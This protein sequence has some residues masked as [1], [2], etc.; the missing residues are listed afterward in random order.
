MK[1]I[2]KIA[3]IGGGFGGWYTATALQYNCPHVELVIID[4]QEH[5][6]I[7]VGEVTGFDAPIHY[8][9][10]I[11]VSDPAELFKQTGAIYKFGT[12]A[13]NFYQDNHSVSWGKFPNLKIKS[14]K[15]FFQ[16]W[17]EHDFYE[18]WNRQPGDV[19]VLLAWMILN[20][21]TGKTYDD[22]QREVADQNYFVNNPCAPVLD[23]QLFLPQKNSYGYQV[24]ADQTIQFLKNLVYTRDYSRFNHFKSPVVTVKR[25]G[26]EVTGVVLEDGTEV[27]ADLFIDASGMHR[28]LMKTGVNS[29]WTPAGDDYNNAAWVFPSAYKN[30]HMELTGSTDFYGEDH[31]WRF[32]VRLYHRMGN[33]YIFNKNFVDPEVVKEDFLRVAGETKLKDPKLIQWTPGHYAEPWQGNVIPVG[34]AGWFIDPWNAPTFDLHSKSLEDLINMIKNWDLIEDHRAHFNKSRAL[35]AEERKLRLDINFGL[36]KRSGPF[37][38]RCREMAKNNG[39]LEKLRDLVLEKRTDLEERLNWYW[40]H[41]YIL[42]AIATGVDTTTWEFPELTYEDKNMVDAYFNYTK[43]RNHYIS[44]YTWPN[45][46]EWLRNKVFNNKESHEMLAILNPDLTK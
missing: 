41:M 22:Y 10:L 37:W 30:P 29:S 11:G 9:R 3:I 24:D 35:N 8:S 16:P 13:I 40:I 1:P 25:E 15:N 18:P 32:K 12:N 27:N 31:G 45:Y 4:S 5:A 21:N 28:V 26:S 38:D 36:S 17:D 19:G 23:R 42:V 44:R 6:P 46:Y 39:T 2:Q 33:G 34:I 20:R 7:G 43:E 14:L